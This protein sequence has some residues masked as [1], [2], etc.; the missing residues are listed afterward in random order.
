MLRVLKINKLTA[1]V[2]GL[3]TVL[4]ASLALA[5]VE[6]QIRERIKP[7]GEV[8]VMGTA[9][10][11]GI[12]AAGAAS[13]EPMEAA[14]IYQNFCTTCHATGVNKAPIYGDA[15]SWAP[16]ISKGVDVLYESAINGFNNGAMPPKGLCMACSNEDL[17]AAVDYMLESVQ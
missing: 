4:S 12:A 15:E 5:A 6:D 14:T 7:A 8:C 2:F 3:L 9:C 1:I 13:G 16:H 10:A 11:A 17:H